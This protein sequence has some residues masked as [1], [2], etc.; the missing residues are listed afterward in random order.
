MDS[1]EITYR[2]ELDTRKLVLVEDKARDPVCS[3]SLDFCVV[4]H[5]P[6]ARGHAGSGMFVQFNST[7]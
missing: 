2:L 7:L 5:H 4:L 1:E 3:G 6:E